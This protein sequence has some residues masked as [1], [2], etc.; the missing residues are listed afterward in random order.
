M[1]IEYLIEKYNKLVY[2]ICYDMLKNPLDAEDA[3]QETYINLYKSFERYKDLEEFELKNILCKI[4]LNKC[5][6]VIKSKSYKI[7]SLTIEYDNSIENIIGIE[8]VEHEILQNEKKRSI[9]KAIKSI[10]EPY[11]SIL[12]DYYINEFSLD[13]IA[14]KNKVSKSTLKMQL[15]RAKKKFK[16]IINGGESLL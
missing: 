12:Y 9:L 14:L 3:V 15:Y 8:D 13:E 4:A 10:K 16:E 6:D 11:S 2:K 7:R 1:G 5:K